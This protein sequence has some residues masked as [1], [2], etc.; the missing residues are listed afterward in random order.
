MSTFYLFEAAAGF[1]LFQCD[2]VDETN[3][4]SKQIQK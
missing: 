2:S 3:V 4:K 1:A